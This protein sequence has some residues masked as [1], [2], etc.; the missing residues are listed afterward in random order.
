MSKIKFTEAEKKKLKEYWKKQDLLFEEY[1]NKIFSLQ[2]KM[3]KDLKIEDIEFFWV[4][5]NIVG[6][7]SIDRNYELLQ[8]EE[9]R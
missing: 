3:Q 8:D 9:L 2:E 5:G 4:E 1:I 6:I 7:G